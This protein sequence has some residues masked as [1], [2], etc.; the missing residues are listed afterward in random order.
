VK[1]DKSI[2]EEL[3]DDPAGE[4]AA[5]ARAE[6]DV[7]AGRLISHAS[8]TRWLKSWGTGKRLR[9]PIAGD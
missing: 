8:M 4:A 1:L 6:A 5:D 2:F 3:A 7:R 9:K